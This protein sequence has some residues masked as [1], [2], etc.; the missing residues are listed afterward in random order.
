[1]RINAK[2]CYSLLAV[3]ELAGKFDDREPG[4]G[5]RPAGQASGN[6]DPVRVKDLSARTGV[7]EGFLVQIL[8]SLR[9]AGVVESV[10]GAGGGYRLAAPPGDITVG[11]VL[12]AA[13]GSGEYVEASSFADAALERGAGREMTRALGFVLSE[14]ERALARVFDS[15]TLAAVRQRGPGRRAAPDYQI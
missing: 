10:R 15:I 5:T 12:R 4:T 11:R 8:Q 9:K 2:C 7:P 13:E 1:V 3:V 14:A 6:G